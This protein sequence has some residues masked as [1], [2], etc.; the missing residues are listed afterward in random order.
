MGAEPSA[1]IMRSFSN[2]TYSMQQSWN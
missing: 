1:V 2:N